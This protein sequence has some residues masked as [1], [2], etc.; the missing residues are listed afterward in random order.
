MRG[1]PQSGF[2]L[3]ELLIAAT[4]MMAI[5][6]AVF[7]V[8]TPSSGIMQVQPEADDL[9][10]RLRV[11][12]ETLQKDLL[13]A[14]SGPYI[15]RS[16]GP[17]HNYLA[18]ILPYLSGAIGNPSAGSYRSD[19]ISLLYVPPTSGQATIRSVGPGGSSLTLLVDPNCGAAHDRVCG[20][21]A[22]TRVLAM[23]STGRFDVGDV[24]SVYGL[25]VQLEGGN[26]HG[27]VDPARGARLVA[28]EWHSYWLDPGSASV[29]PRLM[30]SHGSSSGFPAVDHVVDLRFDYAGDPRPPTVLTDAD[31]E[32]L[33][34]PWTTY[35]PRPPPIGIDDPRDSWPAGENCVFVVAGG[36]HVPR[37]A[38]STGSGL[39]PL[40]ASTLTDG[41][42]CPDASDPRRFDADLLRIR[43]VRILV[44]AE[45]APAWLRGP[46]GPLF[47]RGG[48]STGAQVPD[49]EI[50]FAVAPRNMNLVP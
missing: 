44:R 40:D 35:G 37:L 9:Q 17:L 4:I 29:A 49:R 24:E 39:V 1:S 34:G 14:G 8:L 38:T 42:W 15:G 6:G 2:S 33:E 30:H 7:S 36:A 11:A 21:A 41:P 26:F 16:G 20:F 12:I 28:V 13:M 50:R 10:Q 31:L 46:L 32:S 5:T 43:L 45:V 25:T 27:L 18:P 22:G 23:D 19:E 47:A 48:T 3:V